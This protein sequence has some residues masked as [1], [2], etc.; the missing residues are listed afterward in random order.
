MYFGPGVGLLWIG[1]KSGL[2]TGELVTP[3]VGKSP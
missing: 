3:T 2:R 1:G